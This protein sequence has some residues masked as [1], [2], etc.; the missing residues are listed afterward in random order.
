MQSI[1]EKNSIV[2]VCENKCLFIKRSHCI[3]YEVN[4]SEAGKYY[5]LMRALYVKIITHVYKYKYQ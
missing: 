3:K 5:K 1:N 2:N 4:T